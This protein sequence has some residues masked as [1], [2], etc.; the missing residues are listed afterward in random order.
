M[1]RSF[2]LGALTGAVGLIAIVGVSL[3]VFLSRGPSVLSGDAASLGPAQYTG[4]YNLDRLDAGRTRIAIEN[5]RVIQRFLTGGIFG[6]KA[7]QLALS[8][9]HI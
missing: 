3:M 4:L 8:L 2:F 1:S 6:N 7:S 5:P 9:I